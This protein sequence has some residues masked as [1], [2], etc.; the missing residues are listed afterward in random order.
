MLP[1]SIRSSE[2][3]PPA[4]DE[5]RGGLSGAVK[6]HGLI[7]QMTRVMIVRMEL[8]YVWGTW[9]RD[10]SARVSVLGLGKL[11]KRV[12]SKRTLGQMVG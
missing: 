1:R 12:A 2:I 11:T 6:G 5:C 7:L 8:I 9:L 10:Q 3:V 4:R